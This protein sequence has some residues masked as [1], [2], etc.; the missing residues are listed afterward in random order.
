MELTLRPIRGKDVT[1]TNGRL[2]KAYEVY[3][4]D[5][6]YVGTLATSA[7]PV[8]LRDLLGDIIIEG[9]RNC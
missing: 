4:R 9:G 8:E 7:N 2:V 3:G 5:H 1:L 6:E